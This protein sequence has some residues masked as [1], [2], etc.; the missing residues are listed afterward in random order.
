MAVWGPW[1]PVSLLHISVGTKKLI[2]CMN[3][4]SLDGWSHLDLEARLQ[5]RP[6]PQFLHSPEPLQAW[7]CPLRTKG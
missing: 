4:W 3:A 2:L 7:L 6:S 1:L 5:E